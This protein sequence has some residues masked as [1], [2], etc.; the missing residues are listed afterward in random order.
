MK[1]NLNIPN[2]DT[3]KN[4]KEQTDKLESIS[5]QELERLSHTLVWGTYGR[6][7]NQP[8]QH[9]P[10]A[11]LTPDHIENILVNLST[12]SPLMKKVMIYVMKK[13]LSHVDTHYTIASNSTVKVEIKKKREAAKSNPEGIRKG[14]WVSKRHGFPIKPSRNANA[15]KVHSVRNGDVK[16]IYR[17]AVHP[18]TF[19][20]S[21]LYKNKLGIKIS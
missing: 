12:P 16:L 18:A 5:E 10:V 7:L 14:D 9:K 15:W 6:E 20:V 8:L 13:K 1:T 3:A 2:I 4:L 21:E 19:K 11:S 17:G